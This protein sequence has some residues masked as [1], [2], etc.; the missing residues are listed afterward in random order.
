MGVRENQKRI[1]RLKKIV[2]VV[3]TLTVV[4]VAYNKVTTVEDKLDIV[5][6]QLEIKFAGD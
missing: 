1:K 6:E 4:L 2:L 5:M 3:F